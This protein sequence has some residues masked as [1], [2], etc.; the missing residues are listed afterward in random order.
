MKKKPKR[1]KAIAADRH[2]KMLAELPEA[3]EKRHN[4]IFHRNQM[5]AATQAYNL[6]I[7]RNR[8]KSHLSDFPSGLQ[9][10]AAELH[11][12]DLE[13]KI[14]RFFGDDYQCS[15]MRFIVSMNV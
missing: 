14:H 13:R 12:G 7:E 1:L 11:M 6:N 10:A 5:L 4:N 2:R 8:V 3:M 15:I 9:R